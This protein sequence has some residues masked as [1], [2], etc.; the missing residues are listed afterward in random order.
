MLGQETVAGVFSLSH[1]A[2]INTVTTPLNT[3]SLLRLLLA[4]I[5]TEAFSKTPPTPDLSH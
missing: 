2:A 1:V 4:G 3:S 5:P